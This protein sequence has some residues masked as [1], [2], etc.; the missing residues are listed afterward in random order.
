[1]RKQIK[2]RADCNDVGWMKL[3]YVK[4]IPNRVKVS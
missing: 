1:M 2:S 4:W 3:S